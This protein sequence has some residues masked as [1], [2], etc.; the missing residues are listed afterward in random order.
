MP[1]SHGDYTYSRSSKF[2]QNIPSDNSLQNPKNLEQRKISSSCTNCINVKKENFNRLHS[3]YERPVSSYMKIDKQYSNTSKSNNSNIYF[4]NS[5]AFENL[6]EA[7]QIEEDINKIKNDIPRRQVLTNMRRINKFSVSSPNQNYREDEHSDTHLGQFPKCER[8][9]SKLKILH[10]NPAAKFRRR[11]RF[12]SHPHNEELEYPSD[13]DQGDITVLTSNYMYNS[14]CLIPKNY[15][16]SLSTE[17]STDAICYNF[18]DSSQTRTTKM[19][20]QQEFCFDNNIYN[21]AFHNQAELSC[22]K[23]AEVSCTTCSPHEDHRVVK[24][25]LHSSINKNTSISKDSLSASEKTNP[26]EANEE[27]KSVKEKIQNILKKVHSAGSVD[28]KQLR[29]HV[30]V[31]PH[32]K[33]QI[34]I[35]EET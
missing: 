30:D 6:S 3:Q 21:E 12:D 15:K 31:L 25:S 29:I 22:P 17:C 26:R 28:P 1:L 14:K 24:S 34:R 10:Q 9:E 20:K 8:S 16:D 4:R 33:T 23:N 5:Y 32:Q 35:P 11:N 27:K 13:K 7:S 19:C 18:G 2:F